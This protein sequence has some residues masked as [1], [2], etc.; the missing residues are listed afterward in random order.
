MTYMK[1]PF[2]NKF[3]WILF[4]ISTIPDRQCKFSAFMDSLITSYILGTAFVILRMKTKI[5]TYYLLTSFIAK[6]DSLTH[7]FKPAALA[8]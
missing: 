4:I 5:K 8:A 7:E 2:N 3:T 1:Y 6:L